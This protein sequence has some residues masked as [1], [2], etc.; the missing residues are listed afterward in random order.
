MPKQPRIVAELGRPETAEE[1]AARRAENSR[2]H[3]ANQT[4]LNL[5]LALG[6]SLGVVLLIVLVVVRPDQPPPS[7]VDYMVVAAEAQPGSPAPLAAPVLPDGWSAN[8]ARLS[9]DGGDSLIWNI[10]FLTPEAGFI[11]LD[12]G[13]GSPSDWFTRQLGDSRAGEGTKETVIDGVTWAV[14]DRRTATDPGNYEY[15]LATEVDGVK[16]LLHGSANDKQFDAL[17]TALAADFPEKS[18]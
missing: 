4:V 6:A 3:R 7:P 16:Y 1:S 13:I 9:S 15:S 11:A 14:Y 12:Q 8:A 2:K 5:V 17:A 18:P 10:G